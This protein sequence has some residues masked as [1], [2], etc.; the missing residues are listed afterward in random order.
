M[1]EKE[2]GGIL[3]EFAKRGAEEQERG[4]KVFEA[5]YEGEPTRAPIESTLDKL[6]QDTPAPSN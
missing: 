1:P 2:I 6:A 3:Q 4:Q 5:I